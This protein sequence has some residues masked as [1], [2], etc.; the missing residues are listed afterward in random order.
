MVPACLPAPDGYLPQEILQSA[1]ASANP[2]VSSL[3]FPSSFR[4]VFPQQSTDQACVKT[5]HNNTLQSNLH[6]GCFG[7]NDCAV[8]GLRRTWGGPFVN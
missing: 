2:F 3:H 6:I 8:Q 7:Q 1:H 4:V 5:L